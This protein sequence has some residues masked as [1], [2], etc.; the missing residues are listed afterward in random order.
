MPELGVYLVNP[1][2]RALIAAC[3]MCSG[4]SKSGSPAPNPQTSIPS[5]FIAFALASMLRVREGV[6]WLAVKLVN[7]RFK[8]VLVNLHDLH[9]A[10]GVLNG[11][12]SMRGIDH[13]GLAKFLS[14]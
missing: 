11:I 2:C 5:A 1:L 9:L 12:G 13:D 7:Q 10:L 3:L 6:S 14:N 8:I 4:V